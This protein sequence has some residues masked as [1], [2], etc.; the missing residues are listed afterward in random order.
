[1]DKQ[2]CKILACL[3][4]DC[5]QDWISIDCKAILKLTFS[6][7]MTKF[8]AGFSLRTGRRSHILNFLPCSK[9]QTLFGT[10]QSKF[11]LRKCSFMTSILSSTK[12][13]STITFS[14]S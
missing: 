7:F 5:I 11:N 1:M 13:N 10:S 2:I 14:L 3:H 6:E 8:I 9:D 12:T 4:D